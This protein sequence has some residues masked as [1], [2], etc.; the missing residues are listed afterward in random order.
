MESTEIEAQDQ[1]EAL[2]ESGVTADELRSA[3]EAEVE[4]VDVDVVAEEEEA[5]ADVEAEDAEDAE[6]A[7]ETEEADAPEVEEDEVPDEPRSEQEEAE[8]RSVTDEPAPTPL[9]EIITPAVE[10]RSEKEI[11]MFNIHETRE[12]TID[13]V[14]DADEK[15]AVLELG[16]EAVELSTSGIFSKLYDRIENGVGAMN[17]Q[18]A[19]QISLGH[20]NDVKIPKVDLK[21]QG[22]GTS[23]ESAAY[24][25]TT[26]TLSSTNSQ[27]VKYTGSEGISEET[28]LSSEFAVEGMIA[29]SLGVQIA[30]AY[31]VAATAAIVAGATTIN[32]TTAGDVTTA[33]LHNMFDAL[34]RDEDAVNGVW[35][36]KRQTFNALVAGLVDLDTNQKLGT[37]AGGAE[38]ELLGRPV[39]FSSELDDIASGN[40]PIFYGNFREALINRVERL[41][42]RRDE[43]TGM[44]NGQVFYHGSVFAGVTVRD[45]SAFVGLDIIA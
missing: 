41:Q 10:A 44:A 32:S 12:A 40:T 7:E 16:G 3:D 27:V 11:P 29:R 19:E 24:N 17:A 6:E 23:A 8:E 42:V 5:P 22:A 18:L 14:T 4:V 2:I 9:A 26:T 28:L 13:L 36:M 37:L 35:V 39:I 21:S 33:D 34:T 38:R 1:V 43:Y 45:A 15:R 25:G 20:I 30:R 31:N